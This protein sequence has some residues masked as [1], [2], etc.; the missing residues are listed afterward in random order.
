VTAFVR[1]AVPAALVAYAVIAVVAER[2]WIS[3]MVAPLL[4]ALLWSRHPRGR[5][6]AYIFF[7]VAAARGIIRAVWPL[8]VF[9]LVGIAVLQTP[10]ARRIW[11]RLERRGRRRATVTDGAV[12]TPDSVIRDDRMA[13]P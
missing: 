2:W 13:R 11:P 9:A 8:T 3:G 7:T 10:A 12:L 1:V 5:F 4:A 6:S